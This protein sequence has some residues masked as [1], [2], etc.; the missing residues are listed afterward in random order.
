MVF[1]VAQCNEKVRLVLVYLASWNFFSGLYCGSIIV[2]VVAASLRS[3]LNNCRV[4]GSS[5]SVVDREKVYEFQKVS[6]AL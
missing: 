6:I 1:T 5:T 3:N 4:L 2:C